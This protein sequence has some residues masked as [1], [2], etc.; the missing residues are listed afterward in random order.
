M[1]ETKEFDIE[2]VVKNAYEKYKVD[3]MLNVCVALE[4]AQEVIETANKFKNVWASVGVHP[5]Y[6]EA[7]SPTVESL[8]YWSK[9][10]KVVAIGETGLDFFHFKEEEAYAWQYANFLP[11]IEA[12]K[13]SD[14]PVIIHC[15]E[16]EKQV[17]DILEREGARDCGG[18][19]HCFEGDM[20]CAK[21]ALDI[22]FY[23]SFSGKLT[24]KKLDTLREVAK[25]IP[26]ERLLIET[27][28]PYLSPVPHR[29][30]PNQPG[31]V[32]YTAECLADLHRMNLKDMAQI[33][34]TNFFRCFPAASHS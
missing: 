32:S 3:G 27:D 9:K 26:L 22:G 24:F 1:L 18:V 23:I 16:A 31:Y 12:A 6:K 10:P 2:D 14:L 20:E 21:R 13:Q 19:M 30:K 28:A 8:L 17:M 7:R 34:R 4:S 5:C 15:R 29:G 25:K 33:T 11:Q